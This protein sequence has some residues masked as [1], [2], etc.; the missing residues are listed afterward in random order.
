L[1]SD[2]GFSQYIELRPSTGQFSFYTTFLTNPNT[3][4]GQIVY[5]WNNTIEDQ[6]I[7]QTGD[8]LFIRNVENKVAIFIKS[9]TTEIFVSSG[10]NWINFKGPIL[11]D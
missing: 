11:Q 8:N 9:K 4:S 3:C 1:E 10:S 7:D 6:G 5:I 2:F